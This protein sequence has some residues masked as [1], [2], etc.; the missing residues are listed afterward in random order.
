[1]VV[2]TDKEELLEAAGEKVKYIQK[3]HWNGFLTTTEKYNQ[4]IVVW[5]DVKKT[6]EKE[7]KSLFKTDNHIYNFIDSGAR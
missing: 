3:N 1:M 7:M 2:P 5:A 6:I 4:S